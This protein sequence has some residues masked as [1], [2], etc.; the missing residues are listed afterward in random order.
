MSPTILPLIYYLIAV[1]SLLLLSVYFGTPEHNRLPIMRTQKYQ[2]LMEFACARNSL[3]LHVEFTRVY[4]KRSSLLCTKI[5]I[6]DDKC[7]RIHYITV[8]MPQPLQCACALVTKIH[9]T[10]LVF[11]SV[12]LGNPAIIDAPTN[13]PPIHGE[14]ERIY[15]KRAH[16]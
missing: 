15:R 8:L 5:F 16:N 7:V 6:P 9:N 11:A 2:K 14:G 12:F 10:H 1:I 4:G 3:L 13:P